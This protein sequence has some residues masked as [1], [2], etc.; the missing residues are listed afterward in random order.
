MFGPYPDTGYTLN[1]TYYRRL[2]SLQSTT[3][4]WFTENA[5]DLLM[6]AGKWQ[7]YVF[8]EDAEKTL[9]WQ[10]Q[11]EMIATRVQEEDDREQFSGSPTHCQPD[12]SYL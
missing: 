1:G 6:A 9:Y 7:I 12:M 5:P 10:E 4:N 2:Q 3:T 8:K 11:F